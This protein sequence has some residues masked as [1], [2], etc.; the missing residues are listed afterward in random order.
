LDIGAK[1]EQEMLIKVAALVLIALVLKVVFFK[2][3]ELTL[4]F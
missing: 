3:I 2:Q 1:I 4:A